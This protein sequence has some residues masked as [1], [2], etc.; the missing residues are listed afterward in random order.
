MQYDAAFVEWAYKNMGGACNGAQFKAM[1]AASSEA[2]K[3]GMEYKVDIPAPIYAQCGCKVSWKY[4]EDHAEAVCAA[5]FAKEEAEKAERQ[6]YDFGYQSPGSIGKAVIYRIAAPAMFEYNGNKNEAKQY[7]KGSV[8]I[9][10]E[11]KS[12]VVCMANG[13]GQWVP[14]DPDCAFEAVECF[15]VCFP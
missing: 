8:V 7:P 1:F 11:D 2:A 14:Q 15:R 9:V 3:A 13:A 5:N 6:G 12:K 4:Y 10:S